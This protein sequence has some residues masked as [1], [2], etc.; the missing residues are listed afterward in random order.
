[1]NLDRHPRN[2]HF[3]WRQP[4]GP[5]RLI[6]EA[7]AQAYREDGFFVLEH[8]FDRATIRRLLDEI[9]PLEAQAERHLRSQPAGRIGIS[10]AGE[11]T[12]RPHLVT[13]S[14]YIRDFCRHPVFQGLVHDLIGPDVR[15]YW[16]QLVYKKPGNAHEFP[17]HQ[18]NGYTYVV[19]QQYLTCW[20]ALTDAT[21]ENGCPWVVP[22]IHRS[23][24]LRHWPTDLGYQC[25]A[26]PNDARALPL[27]AGDVAVFSSLT[28]HRTGPNHTQN[29]RKA[30]IVQFAPDGAVMFREGEAPS[31]CDAPERQYFVLIGG[32][33]A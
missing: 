27:S 31:V 7:L 26:E 12:F 9:D 10:R 16:D 1:M 8:A 28:P 23:G 18:D 33:P 17:W 25:L 13:R 14:T 2:D 30:Y 6:S 22:G 5:F 32:E 19:P 21:T 24:T 29:V 15:L 3:D 4:D 11:I 20:V